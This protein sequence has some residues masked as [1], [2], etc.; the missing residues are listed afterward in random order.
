MKFRFCETNCLPVSPSHATVSCIYPDRSVRYNDYSCPDGV[1]HLP[2]KDCII[3]TWQRCNPCVQR[4]DR[5]QYVRI[6]SVVHLSTH[7]IFPNVVVYSSSTCDYR[8]L[9]PEIDS[10]LVRM[11]FGKIKWQR[12]S[13]TLHGKNTKSIIRNY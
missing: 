5:K 11:S 12:L 1:I 9:S 2:I 4:P 6:E 10:I 3:I 8:W 13:Q 7:C